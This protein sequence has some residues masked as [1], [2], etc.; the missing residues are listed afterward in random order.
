[1]GI[2]KANGFAIDYTK[3]AQHE[4]LELKIEQGGPHLELHF[5]IEG[6]KLFTNHTTTGRDIRI[7]SGT[8]TLLFIPDL[9]G[10]LTFI[11]ANK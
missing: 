10:D 7:K 1:M 5:E 6:E 11:A 3:L 4:T 2:L 8:H 9:R